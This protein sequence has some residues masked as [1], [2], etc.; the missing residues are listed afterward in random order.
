MGKDKKIEDERFE[1]LFGE[2]RPVKQD[3]VTH[4]RPRPPARPR[5]READEQQVLHDMLS[6]EYDPADV[7]TGDELLFCQAGI[8]QR[9]L[10]KLRRGQFPI[11]AECDLHGMTVI[12]ARP[13]LAAFLTNSRLHHQTCVRIIHGKGLGSKQKIPVLKN[14]VNKWLRQRE[15]VLAFCTARPIDGGAGAMYVLLKAQR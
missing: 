4:D 5:F 7:E 1:D 6:D 9:T 11:S 10:K 2:V 12:E 13:Y 14:K 8:Q 15:E 3:R